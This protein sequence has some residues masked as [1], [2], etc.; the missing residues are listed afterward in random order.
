MSETLYRKVGRKYVPVL[1]YDPLVCDSFPKGCHVVVSNPGWTLYRFNIQPDKAGLV[2]AWAQI[3]SELANKIM[4]IT[5]AQPAKEYDKEKY[6][7]AYEKF[8]SETG[9]HNFLLTYP[10]ATEI[11]RKIGE[12]LIGETNGTATW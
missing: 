9:I 4:E 3:E 11:A 8:V 7:V 1:E 2:A 6:R 10:S 5:K 12:L